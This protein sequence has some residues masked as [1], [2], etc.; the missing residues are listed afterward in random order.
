MSLAVLHD[1]FTANQAYLYADGLAPGLA[2]AKFKQETVSLKMLIK[3]SLLT[4]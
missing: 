3:D 1:R 2:V 4:L